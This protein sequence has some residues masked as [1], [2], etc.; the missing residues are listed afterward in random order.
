M[1]IPDG[2]TSSVSTVASDVARKLKFSEAQAVICSH[3][4]LV[5]GPK[6]HFRESP[7]TSLSTCPRKSM[8]CSVALE[9]HLD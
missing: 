9:A 6:K 7:Q 5:L 4:N 3:Q 8:R 1:E 2:Q